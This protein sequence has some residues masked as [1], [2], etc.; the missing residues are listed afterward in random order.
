FTYAGWFG[1]PE[2]PELNQDAHGHVAGPREYIFACTRR[3]MDPAAQPGGLPAGLPDGAYGIDGWRLDV[4]FC[5]QHGFWRDWRRLV[6]ALN[7]E[8][9]LFAEIVLEDE[10]EPYLR[11]DEFDGVMNYRWFF[12]CAEFFAGALRR[13]TASEFDRRLREL[14]E[15]HPVGVAHGQYNLL[16]SHDTTRITSFLANRATGYFTTWFRDYQG[17]AS[18]STTPTYFT[19]RPGP[20]EQALHRLM[21]LFQM[22]YVGAPV[23]YYGDEAGLW[24]A[25]DP[26]C[27]KPMVWPDLTYAPESA[28][29]DGARYPAPDPVAFDQDLFAY[30]RRLIALRHSLPALQLGDY[31]TLLTDDAAGVL[32]FQ[33]TLGGE[34]VAVVINTRP[35]AQAVS[36]PLAGAWTDVFN[37]GRAYPA[38]AG[39]LTVEAPALSGCILKAAA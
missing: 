20:E 23:V 37:G 14:R 22:T 12:A 17:K 8:A 13:T 2:L 32:A 1:V 4:A 36:L 9:Y 30:H 31:Q 19:R 28:G 29:P 34:R 33:R 10:D 15:A 24:G 25:N 7:P 5:I 18:P 3:W 21:V 27:R 26:C 6:K 35:A 38:A 39:G 11:G 16:D